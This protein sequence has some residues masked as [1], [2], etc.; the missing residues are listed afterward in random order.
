MNPFS[1]TTLVSY[2]LPVAGSAGLLFMTSSA[3]KV[4]G[5][6]RREQSGEWRKF[7]SAHSW[8]LRGDEEIAL[9]EVGGHPTSLSLICGGG[10]FR[11]PYDLRLQTHTVACPL[12]RGDC[13]AGET[14]FLLDRPARRRPVRWRGWATK[15]K[16]P[17][18]EILANP[19]YTSI[20][21]D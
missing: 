3:G 6:V 4:R 15:M 21:P 9:G 14:R 1:P 10:S 7:L 8:R 16:S 12:S 19:T 2:Q 20:A 13:F 5:E 17:P 18:P 11:R